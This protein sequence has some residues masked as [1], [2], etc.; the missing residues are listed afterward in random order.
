MK[1]LHTADIHIRNYKDERW[2]TLQQIVELCKSQNVDVLTISGDLFDSNADA[3][4]S[5]TKIRELFSETAFSVFIIPGNHDVDSY[6]EGTFLGD[7][8]AIIRDYLNPVEV[9]NVFFWGFPYQDLKEEEVMRRL[10]DMS[11]LATNEGTHILLFHGELLDTTGAWENYGSE[12][13]RRYVPVKLDFFRYLNWK[14]I[15]AGHYHTNFDIHEFKENRFFV[16]PGSPVSITK[17]ELGPRKVNLFEIDDKPAPHVLSSPYYEAVE[18]NLDPFGKSPSDNF[19][20]EE[21]EKLPNNAKILLTVNGFFDGKKLGKTEQDLQKEIK[22][23]AGKRTET[24]QLEFRDIHDILE[25]DLFKLFDS[26][27]KKSK[28]DNL[29]KDKIRNITIKV[30]MEL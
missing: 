24:L 29:E 14:Y 23:A 30:M 22:E 26:K 25:D 16:Y 21:I 18:I 2:N 20:E 19:L 11:S 13:Q 6:P 8:V 7:G 3:N 9:D 4:K 27:L 10:Y 17:K 28:I 1:I 5:R 12:G 15:L